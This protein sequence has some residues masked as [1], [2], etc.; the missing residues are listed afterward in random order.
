VKKTA[1]LLIPTLLIAT[2]AFAEE[3]WRAQAA[4]AVGR[5]I[6]EQGN[7]A[8]K[9]IRAEVAANLAD[10]IKP[11]LPEAREQ[12]AENEPESPKL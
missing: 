12:P 9:E 2:P 3:D 5:F 7:A 10:R 11:L 4:F 6:A 1:L 8:L